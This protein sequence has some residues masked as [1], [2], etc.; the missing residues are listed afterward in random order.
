MILHVVGARPQF[1]KLLPLHRA[2]QARG[3]EQKILHTGQHWEAGMSEVFFKE[4]GLQADE[5]LEWNEVFEK[6]VEDIVQRM[7]AWEPST[8]VVYGDTYS[9]LCAARAASSLQLP[10]AHVE[11]GL[12]SFNT[13]MPE[14]HCRVETDRMSDWHFAPVQSALEH[15]IAEGVDRTTSQTLMT[16][17]IMADELMHLPDQN[18]KKGQILVTLHRNTNVDDED[19]RDRILN[20]IHQLALN[21]HEVLWPIHPRLRNALNHRQA[22]KYPEIQ[23]CEPM[24]REQIV[25]AIQQSEWVLTDSGGLQKEAYF[26][27]RPAIILRTETEWVELLETGQSFLQNPQDDNLLQAIEQRLQMNLGRDFPPIYGDGTAAQRMAAAL[28]DQ[29]PIVPVSLNVS[30]DQ[31]SSLHRYAGALVHI[32]TG[33]KINWTSEGG[34]PIDEPMLN[35]A[36]GSANWRHS[37]LNWL[38][39]NGH[40]LSA[41]VYSAMRCEEDHRRG[42]LYDAHGRFEA[43]HSWS[44]QQDMLNRPVVEEWA[45][46]WVGSKGMTLPNRHASVNTVVVDVDHAMAEQGFPLWHRLASSIR[47][48]L[49]GRPASFGPKDPFDARERFESLFK[50]SHW[51]WQFFMWLGDRGRHDRGLPGSTQ[52]AKEIL[53]WLVKR[54]PHTGM[55][56]SYQGHTSEHAQ[57]QKRF[58]KYVGHLPMRQRYHYL[59][60]DLDAL[61]QLHGSVQDWTMS[62]ATVAGY[63][64]GMA[65]P[66][67]WYVEN[68][69]ISEC[70]IMVPVWAMDQQFAGK[71]EASIK[72]ALKSQEAYCREQNIPLVVATHW[73]F[74]GCCPSKADAS[75]KPFEPWIKALTDIL[76]P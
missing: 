31:V 45:K 29:G 76:V 9:T 11:A 22:E 47:R 23:W 60:M 30:H 6:T 34:I 51:R 33:V 61:E 13:N 7:Q 19:I 56:P 70:P 24:S 44:F 40:M 39:D 75:A 72:A 43:K 67:P 18:P 32:A 73:R 10:L 41:M 68:V 52:K 62:Y 16:G 35:D 63:R 38:I 66:Y 59:K 27:R 20:A 14:E 1:I 26:L 17:D 50:Q 5:V 21:G 53:Q 28:W 74:F 8:V 3:A 57:E 42:Q 69:T 4:F 36:W 64:A 46:A 49:S 71:D 2:L 15:L 37:K 48:L 65:R 12:R 55:H 54:Q 25:N 58:E